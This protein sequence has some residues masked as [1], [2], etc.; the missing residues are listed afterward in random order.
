MDRTPEEIQARF[1]GKLVRILVA[2]WLKL[3]EINE[4]GQSNGE[5]NV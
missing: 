1:K 2:F 3:Q 4:R 5:R